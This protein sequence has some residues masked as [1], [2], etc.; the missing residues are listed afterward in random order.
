MRRMQF[1]KTVFWAIVA[2]IVALFAWVN[3]NPV[4]VN[5]WN[6]I[7][8]DIKLPVLLLI[9]FLIGWLPTWLVMRARLWGLQR[10][11]EAFERNQAAALVADATA[12]AEPETVAEP[13]P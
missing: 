13:A 11:V 2:A 6:D 5:L 10:R 8:A 3:W 12:D 7:Q 4:T 1:L 9:V